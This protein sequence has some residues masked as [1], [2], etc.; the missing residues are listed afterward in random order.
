MK[1]VAENQIEQSIKLLV[2]IL[3]KDLLGMYLYG[4]SIVGGLQKYSDIDLFVVSARRTT[5]EEK[6]GM[7]E[8]LLS[9]SGVYMKSEKYPIELTI[10]EQSQINPW[11]YPPKFDFQYGEWL[12]AQFEDGNSQL[13]IAQEMPDLALL[14]T[15]VKLASQTLIGSSPDKIL[16]QVPYR[17]FMYALQD[18]VQNIISEL[19]ADTRN[20]ILTLAR[21]W[22]TVATDEIRSKSDAA[23]W[24]LSHLPDQYRAVI[25]RAKAICQGKEKEYW[26]DIKDITKDC[27]YF[28]VAQINTHITDVLSSDYSK[29]SMSLST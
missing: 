25:G 13:W 4:S 15:Q 19:D 10:V 17:D 27:A 28:M 3:G 8:R 14:V 18:S 5:S 2:N 26:D 22:S 29:R 16:P 7:I 6:R 1:A 12:R 20:V 9:I 23:D 24:A 21:I 11:H